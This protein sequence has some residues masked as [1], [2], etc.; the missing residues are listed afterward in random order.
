V[1]SPRGNGPFPAIVILHGSHGFAKEYVDLARSFA[2]SGFV[3]MAGC[4]FSGRSGE[5]TRFITP[6][7]CPDAP[8]VSLAS[9]DSAYLAVEALVRTVRDQP[10]VR[11]DPV[12]LFGHS[13]GGRAALPYVLTHRV[14]QALILDPTPYP[15]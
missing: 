5:G 8:P 1:V 14:V 12:A 7:E 4:W 6:I 3:A 13:R 11:P 10:Q 15:L 9:S 2:R